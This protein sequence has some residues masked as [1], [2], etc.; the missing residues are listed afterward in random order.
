MKIVEDTF[1]A[2]LATPATITSAESRET[3]AQNGGLVWIHENP[4]GAVGYAVVEIT[5]SGTEPSVLLATENSCITMQEDYCDAAFAS[6]ALLPAV[7]TVPA[8]QALKVPAGNAVDIMGSARYAIPTCNTCSYSV[9]S[10]VG[11]TI[12]ATASEVLLTVPAG[13]PAGDYPAAIKI[14]NGAKV[15]G[16]TP[17]IRVTQ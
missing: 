2:H 4:L 13:T 14:T 1:N 6:N 5:A 7:I 11:M 16:I 3:T 15:L 9:D 17:T 8:G 10:S 12:E